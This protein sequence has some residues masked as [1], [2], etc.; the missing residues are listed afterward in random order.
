MKITSQG[1]SILI[2]VL[3]LFAGYASPAKVDTLYHIWEKP[4]KGDSIF[5]CNIFKKFEWS[6][7]AGNRDG[8]TNKCVTERVDT[9]FQSNPVDTVRLSTFFYVVPDLLNKIYSLQCSIEGSLLI[10][11]NEQTLLTTGTFDAEHSSLIQSQYKDL[12]FT[13]SLQHLEITYLTYLRS[14]MFEL[15]LRIYPKELAEKKMKEDIK[16]DDE[17][18]G[19]GFYYL[20]FGIVFLS[21]FFFF[22]DKTENLYFSLFCLFAALSF[23]W[24]YRHTD[25]L[26]NLE[27]FFNFFCF[28]FLSIF[29]CKITMNREKSKIPLMVLLALM[30]LCFI[31]AI[32]Y[33]YISLFNHPVPWVIA[34]ISAA[35]YV[36]VILSSL[37]FLARGIG[38]KQWEAKVVL[39][40]CFIP[41]VAL[42][43]GSIIFIVI[44][45]NNKTGDFNNLFS[46]FIVYLNKSIKYIY[47]LAAVII[48]GRRNGLNQ[49]QLIAQVLS[50]Q[51]LSNENLAKEVEKKHILENQKESLEKEVVLR[52]SEI[53][54]Q[55]EEIEKQHDEL[56]VE[57]AKS[58][59][60][61]LNILPSE[62]AEEL[63]MKGNAAARQ[64]DHVTVLF[65][66]FVNFTKVSEEMHPQ[67]LIDE[68]NTCFKA[69]D[70][71]TS[72]YN[73][74][75]IKTIGD[76]YLAVCGL[77]LA[78]PMHAEKAIMAAQEIN[79][80]MKAR[81]AQLGNKSFQVRIGIH[82]GS[83]VAGIVG[84]KKFAYDI[85]GDTVN[86]AAR[87]EQNSEAGKINV[88]QTTYELTKD[89][90]SYEYRG[91]IE[92]KG[93]GHLKMY[94]VKP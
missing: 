42:V 67:E 25:L 19:M 54:A 88:S 48:L 23:L 52:T 79:S 58:D 84:L 77:P 90:F 62:V 22:R 20:A 26:Y 9:L 73:I 76:A 94:Y 85:W 69:F 45:Q 7:V 8:K 56:K 33:N 28:E 72:K 81:H 80:F 39:V 5:Y 36:Y 71:I 31:P 61:L 24:D 27:S 57:K 34:G 64:F 70:D 78:D 47:P 32:R 2:C 38:K 50:I 35:L 75:K 40:I 46:L 11:L 15:G 1:K 91:E 21:L 55:K 29:F 44:S 37:Y 51:Q 87:M 63:K 74:E 86:T 83:V 18:F 10:K 89:K 49:K 13:D 6:V 93:K 59:N 41:V 68:L 17:S 60:L 4:Q 82:S 12:I 14:R 53:V 16:S 92:A 30:A 66:D 65:S 43:I 3:I